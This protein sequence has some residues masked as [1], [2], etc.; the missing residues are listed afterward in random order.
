ML[1]KICIIGIGS[2]GGF[3]CNHLSYISHV[4][5]IIIVDPD[6]VELSNIEKSIYE[7]QDVGM[8]KVD[9]IERKL[10][11]IE[12]TKIPY[13]YQEGKTKLPKCDLVIDCRDIVCSRRGEIDVKFYISENSLI[14]DCKKQVR[15]GKEYPGSYIMKLSKDI[16]NDAAFLA[17]KIIVSGMVY[18]LM[19]NNTVLSLNLD[20]MTDHAQKDLNELIEKQRLQ[21]DFMYDPP[22]GSEK[23]RE[24]E[25]NIKPILAL[26]KDQN[27]PVYIGQQSL[28][29]KFSNLSPSKKYDII[30]K[31]ELTTELDVIT[32]LSNL[33]KKSGGDV[34]FIVTVYSRGNDT[35]VELIQEAGSA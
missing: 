14:I 30:K 19:K 34:N 10:S 5:E 23:L 28:W 4:Q 7:I 18:K 22:P 2:L 13:T 33:V 35:R 3:L 6:I 15:Y 8:A 9:A 32:R 25:P 20:D 26:C 16:I 27:L 17:R 11:S 12:L 21:D 1:S 31:G 24:L 29:K